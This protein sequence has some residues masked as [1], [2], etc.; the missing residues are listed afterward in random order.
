MNEVFGET[1]RQFLE[2]HEMICYWL[3]K[4]RCNHKRKECSV[5]ASYDIHLNEAISQLAGV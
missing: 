2:V 1:K 3:F 5:L 4:K